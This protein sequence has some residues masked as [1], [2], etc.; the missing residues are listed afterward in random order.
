MD[1]RR[2]LSRLSRVDDALSRL[3]RVD[4]ATIGVHVHASARQARPQYFTEQ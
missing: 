2:A 3:S 4:D 1:E